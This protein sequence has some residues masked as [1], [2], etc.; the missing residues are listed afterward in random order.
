VITKKSLPIFLRGG[1]V[2]SV[3]PQ[4]LGY[5]EIRV[6]ELI[7]TSAKEGYKDFLLDIGA[8]I[9]L[10]SCQSGDLFKEVHCYEPNPDCFQILKINTKISLKTCKVVLNNF[11]L[12]LIDDQSQLYVPRG[13]WGG[14]FIHDE[15]NMY[16]DEE[17]SSKDGYAGFSS[18]N[19]EIVSISIK[20]SVPH[21]SQL[22]AELKSRGLRKGFIKID[23]EGYE[24]V[25]LEAIAKSIP[26]NVEVVILFECFTKGFNPTALLE[27]FHGRAK[28]YRLVRSPEKYLGK[29]NR[30]K[31]IFAQFGYVYQLKEFDSLGNATDIVFIVS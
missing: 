6:R 25:V 27:K 13:N 19:Y 21:F 9:G 11:G 29:L 10:S 31:K 16:T 30:L 1:D 5:H 18:D 8:N 23:V 2:I 4:A 24:N 15:A 22:F 14:A 7:N 3:L 12:G 17:V 20:D 26:E 28:P